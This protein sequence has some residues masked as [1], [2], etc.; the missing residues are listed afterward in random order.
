MAGRANVYMTVKHGKERKFIT[1]FILV[2]KAT[3]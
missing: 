3:G 1:Y 2:A